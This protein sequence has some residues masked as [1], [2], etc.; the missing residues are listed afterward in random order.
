MQV[1][2]HNRRDV[3]T[4]SI[5]MSYIQIFVIFFKITFCLLSI[6]MWSFFV[7]YYALFYSGTVWTQYDYSLHLFV[8]T[9]LKSHH[10]KYE[11]DRTILLPVVVHFYLIHLI[12]KTLRSSLIKGIVRRDLIGV[13]NRLKRSVLINCKTALLYYLILKGHHH[14][15]RKN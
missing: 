15:R 12:V 1:L 6:A 7:Y 4:I 10:P 8:W 14:K 13:E 2:L 3:L 11:D 9:A 5:H